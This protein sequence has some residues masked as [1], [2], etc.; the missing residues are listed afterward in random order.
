[1]T[2]ATDQVRIAAMGRAGARM[3]AREHGAAV[4]PATAT[5]PESLSVRRSM[6]RPPQATPRPERRYWL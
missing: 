2:Q 6:S 3:G 4:G 1:M 5:P